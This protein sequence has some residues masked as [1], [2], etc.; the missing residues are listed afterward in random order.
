M[1]DDFEKRSLKY[2][3]AGW[4]ELKEEYQKFKTEYSRAPEWQPF[5][6][7][8]EEDLKQRA[9]LYQIT[10]EQQK[11]PSDV[12]YWKHPGE[13]KDEPSPSRPFLR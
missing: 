7:S 3:R 8:V 1:L 10:D 5:F 4:R 12:T 13:L 11:D 9:L 2:Q 6:S